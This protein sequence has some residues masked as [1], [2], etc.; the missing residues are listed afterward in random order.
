MLPRRPLAASGPPRRSRP[1]T[2]HSGRR[3][4]IS[5]R[6]AREPATDAQLSLLRRCRAR[7]PGRRSGA[8]GRPRP[9]RSDRPCRTSVRGLSRATNVGRRPL[10]RCVQRVHRLGAHVVRELLRVLRQHG[11]R[12]D[13][14][15]HQHIGAQRLPQIHGRRE[16]T[17]RRG[18]GDG[19]SSISSGRMPTITCLPSYPFSSGRPRTRSWTGSR[20]PAELEGERSVRSSEASPPRCSSPASR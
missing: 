18:I 15:V 3:E 4:S 2:L 12:V 11:G 9:A 19:A 13:R 10:A 7:S 20:I 16:A 14:E 8:G 5:S 17:V 6:V 1:R